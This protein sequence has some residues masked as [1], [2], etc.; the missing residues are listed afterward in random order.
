MFTITL[1]LTDFTAYEDYRK[2]SDIILLDLAD[3]KHMDLDDVCKLEAD[4]ADLDR[5]LHEFRSVL[6]RVSDTYRYIDDKAR[7]V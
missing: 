1:D 6:H 2:A 5:A 4:L 3:S 7:H